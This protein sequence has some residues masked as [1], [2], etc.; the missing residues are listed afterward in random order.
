MGEVRLAGSWTRA[1][2]PKP[3]VSWISPLLSS[4]CQLGLAASVTL[5]TSTACLPTLA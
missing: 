2:T 5:V 3:E 4:P 1:A